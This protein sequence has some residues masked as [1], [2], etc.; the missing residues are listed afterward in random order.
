MHDPVDKTIEQLFAD[1][2]LK[3]RESLIDFTQLPPLFRDQIDAQSLQTNWLGSMS[4]YSVESQ[5]SEQFSTK[6]YDATIYIPKSTASRLL[7]SSMER[8]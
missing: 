1:S 2:R 7:P 8:K 6:A 3:E 5:F 4:P